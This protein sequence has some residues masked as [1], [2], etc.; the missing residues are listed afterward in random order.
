MSVAVAD[1][2]TQP[3]GRS[4]TNRKSPSPTRRR[5]SRRRRRNSVV[6]AIDPMENSSRET[7]RRHRRCLTS[8]PDI[9]SKA[10]GTFD[11]FVY[12]LCGHE[13]LTV[14]MGR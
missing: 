7:T 12:R 6:A 10:P 1:P 2:G 9:T 11:V 14:T 3:L 13:A 5:N 4:P 8:T